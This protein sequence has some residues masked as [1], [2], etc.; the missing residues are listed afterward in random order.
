MKPV[1]HDVRK[2]LGGKITATIPTEPDPGRG[3]WTM[4]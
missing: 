1:I 2:R 3:A 4:S